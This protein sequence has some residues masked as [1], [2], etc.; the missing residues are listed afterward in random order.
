MR[1]IM[2]A[3]SYGMIFLTKQILPKCRP[4]FEPELRASQTLVLTIT[5]PT[6]M[7]D[8]VQHAH[9]ASLRAELPSGEAGN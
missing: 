5:P 8:I 1:T 9:E 6:H 7:E 3:V 2:S 4:G